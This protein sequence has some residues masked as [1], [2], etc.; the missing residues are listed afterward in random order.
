MC[1]RIG[2]VNPESCEPSVAHSGL[3]QIAATDRTNPGQARILADLEL[4]RDLTIRDVI[5]TLHCS[6]TVDN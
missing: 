5:R 4:I 3:K 2:G 6:L 1:W